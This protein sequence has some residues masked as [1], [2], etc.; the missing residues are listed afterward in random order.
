MGLDER[1][2]IRRETEGKRVASGRGAARWKRLPSH[3]DFR[4]YH[5]FGRS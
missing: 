3:P 5:E 4:G 2:A 1:E